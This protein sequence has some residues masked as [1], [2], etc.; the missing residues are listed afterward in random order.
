MTVSLFDPR[1]CELGEGAF[2]H[3]EREQAFWFD[4]LNR[5]LLSLEKGEPKSWQF[6]EHVSAA[7]WI[8]HDRLLIASASA[9]FTFDLRNGLR[10]ELAEL[11]THLPGNRSNDG[12]ADPQ[13]GF[14][15]GTMALDEEPGAGAIYRYYHGVLRPLYTGISIPNAICFSPDG[16]TAYF[17][18][19]GAQKLWRQSLD[20]EGWPQERREVLIDFA[21]TG[22][23]PDGAVTDAA[24]NL[25]I[26]QWGAGRLACHGADGSFV[27][28]VA[29]PA[30][31]VTC[32]AFIGAA[33]DRLIVTSAA[34]GLGEAP[35][36]QTFAIDRPG[37]KGL[38]APR[39]SVPA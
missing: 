1:S 37:L 20:A 3:P 9:L 6:D 35:Q 34:V 26:A 32:P 31:Q 38:P 17:A 30:K 29:L 25:W 2:W 19:T 7:G 39:V 28:A 36:G 10:R 23:Y 33:L 21:P 24:G 8:D 15:I 5:R 22:L 12:R 11:E 14:W 16:R 18:D 4:I 13:G 27:E